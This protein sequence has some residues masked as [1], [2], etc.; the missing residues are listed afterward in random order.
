M[1][2]LYIMVDISSK[3]AIL[4]IQSMKGSMH[5]VSTRSR[6]S[7]SRGIIISILSLSTLQGCSSTG[8]QGGIIDSFQK[9]LM[10]DPRDAPWDPPVEVGYGGRI[11]NMQGDV[12]RFCVKNPSRCG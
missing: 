11:P 5:M 2:I 9:G 3:C 10:T 4:Y 1:Y 7:I 6:L 8:G 12:Y